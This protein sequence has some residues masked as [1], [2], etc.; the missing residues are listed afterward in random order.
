MD[1]IA[2]IFAFPTMTG[3]VETFGFDQSRCGYWVAQDPRT[4]KILKAYFD[5]KYHPELTRD[6][7]LARLASGPASM[8]RL[9]RAIELLP[10]F[11]P[12]VFQFRP[13]GSNS[14]EAKAYLAAP[15]DRRAREVGFARLARI[16]AGK[17]R[18]AQ[19]RE[20]LLRRDKACPTFYCGIAF[21]PDL[22]IE[23]YHEAP[24]G[25][26][27][28]LP[29]LGKLLEASSQSIQSQSLASQIWAM[30]RSCGM[31]CSQVSCDLISD[32]REVSLYFDPAVHGDQAAID[33]MIDRLGFDP[34]TGR[35]HP[36]GFIEGPLGIKI[37]QENGAMKTQVVRET[38]SAE[39]AE[40]N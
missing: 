14:I 21:R 19:L 2:D 32:S 39:I 27:F 35:F 3:D 37:S 20:N 26:P 15:D 13:S 40:T 17:G 24:D 12:C 5:L 36:R 30:A 38:I 28:E 31:A 9:G 10:R 11:S 18:P 23:T 6:A 22:E 8:R 4:G 33:R 34:M 1:K 7:L 16:C 29:L 25:K